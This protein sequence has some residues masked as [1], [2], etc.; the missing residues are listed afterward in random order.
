MLA[1]SNSHRYA[2]T[3]NQC[4][5]PLCIEIILF[6]QVQ[7]LDMCPPSPVDTCGR[8]Y[9]CNNYDVSRLT[10]HTVYMWVRTYQSTKVKCIEVHS[11]YHY[12]HHVECFDR[13]E[14]KYAAHFWCTC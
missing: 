8:G 11:V 4:T 14:W 13:F 6:Q 12:I 2:C 5:K 10:Q 3:M 1:R 9:F 7:E